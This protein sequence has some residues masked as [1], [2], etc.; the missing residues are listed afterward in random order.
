MPG[1]VLLPG[2]LVRML[3]HS[4]QTSANDNILVIAFRNCAY[5]T[6]LSTSSALDA[7]ITNLVCHSKTPPVKYYTYIVT[8]IFKNAIFLEHFSKINIFQ[9]VF[10]VSLL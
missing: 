10:L 4:T 6:L 7:L 2:K 3:L 1:E 9:K 8:Y 5:R